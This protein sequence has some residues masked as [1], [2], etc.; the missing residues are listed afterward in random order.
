MTLPIARYGFRIIGVVWVVTVLFAILAMFSLG[1][2]TL[3]LFLPALFTLYFFRDPERRAD[4]NAPNAVLA[5]ADGKVVAVS[6]GS[7][8]L[9]GEPASLIDIFLSVFDVH[10]N[11][12]PLAGRV[13][14]TKYTQ[15]RFL[16]ALRAAAGDVNES[17]LIVLELTDGRLIAVKQIAGVIARRVVCAVR[18]GDIVTAGQ[19]FGMIMLGS[20]TQLFIPAEAQFDAAVAVG[21]RVRA[22]ETVLGHIR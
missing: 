2:W 5:P 8:P 17:N 19:R 1:W 12:S 14:A 3:L 18:Q 6:A 22:G 9:S 15:G 4:S 7:M 13:A 16:N 11:R 21:Q 10:V 20:R